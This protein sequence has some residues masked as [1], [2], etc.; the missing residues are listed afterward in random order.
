MQ[1]GGSHIYVAGPGLV[2]TVVT[3]S[4]VGSAVSFDEESLVSAS[5]TLADSVAKQAV[6]RTGFADL[7]GG[8]Q[9]VVSST[10]EGTLTT[11]RSIRRQ[12]FLALT[13][14][15]ALL[16]VLI[17]RQTAVPVPVKS[18]RTLLSAQ[19]VLKH[20]TLHT[21]Q[22]V[23][24]LWAT[25]GVTTPVALSAGPGGAVE[26]VLM[27]A[28][29]V[30]TLSEQQHFVRVTTQCAHP[31]CRACQALGVTLLTDPVP[32]VVK[33]RRTRRGTGASRQQD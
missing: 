5:S 27:S 11:Q 6:G 19:A 25:T 2:V 26:V 1:P 12:T 7:R 22:T 8:I 14:T 31:C 18:G 21:L 4:A 24:P 30:L 33:T 15:P 17:T 28:A 3:V 13:G 9:E 32:I 10:V 23:C 29:V 16:T 20:V